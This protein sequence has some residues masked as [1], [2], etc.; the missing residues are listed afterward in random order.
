M[1][2]LIVKVVYCV[3]VCVWSCEIVRAKSPLE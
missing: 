1:I 3:S 2:H